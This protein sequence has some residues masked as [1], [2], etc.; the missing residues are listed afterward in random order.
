MRAAASLTPA[1]RGELHDRLLAGLGAREHRRVW[2]PSDM[3]RMRSA[4]SSSS[5]SSEL[6]TTMARPSRG[7]PEDEV[8]DLLLG[9]DVD[10][11]GRL[12]EE[13]DARPVASHLPITT[14]CWLPPDSVADDLIDAGAADA[15]RSHRVARRARPRRAKRANAEARQRAERAAGRHC[16]G[17]MT[18]GAGPCALRSSVTS[19]M[20]RRRAS[21]GELMSTGSPSM[22]DRRRRA[23]RARRRRA[24]RG[25][26]CGRSRAG[27]RCRGSR[28]LEVEARRRA[29]T[30]RQP[31]RLGFV[32]GQVAHREHDRAAGW[33]R[34]AARRARAR[35][36][37]SPR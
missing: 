37:P 25:S 33:P 34:L 21:R 26:R 2:R 10:A 14:F 29:S 11:A 18:R 8:V 35:G 16:R 4:R 9:A 12:V 13:Q 24:S 30:R 1:R 7:E 36:R 3:T 6:T 19:A 15:E 27:R 32:E 17:S 5:G 22:R 31:R 28:R 20:P 23:G